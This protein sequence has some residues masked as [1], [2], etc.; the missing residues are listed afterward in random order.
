MLTLMSPFRSE[1]AL[2]AARVGFEPD[3]GLG[4]QAA[5]TDKAQRNIERRCRIALL[6]SRQR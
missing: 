3:A 6:R 2:N 1:P 4:G 5:V